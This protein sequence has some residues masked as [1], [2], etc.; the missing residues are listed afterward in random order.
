MSPEQARGEPAS[1]TSD[2][3]ALGAILYHALA[4]SPPVVDTDVGLVLEKV[5]RSEV[6]PLADVAPGLPLDLVAIVARAMAPPREDRHGTAG[7]LVADLRRFQIGRRANCSCSRR[8]PV[9]RGSAP[10]RSHRRP[11]VRIGAASR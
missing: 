3:Y 9:R 10:R 11:A 6:A 8:H 5:A 4:G 7:E 1:F 2:V